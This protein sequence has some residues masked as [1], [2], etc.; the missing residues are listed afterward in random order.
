PPDLNFDLEP[1]TLFVGGL[2]ATLLPLALILPFFDRLRRVRPL[3]L[4]QDVRNHPSR[5]V[6]VIVSLLP[7]GL[8]FWGLAVWVSHSVKIGSLFWGTLLFVSL[9][10]AGVFSQILKRVPTLVP[11]KTHG[12][13]FLLRLSLRN[14]NGHRLSTILSGLSVTVGALLMGLLP[15]IRSGLQQELEAPSLGQLPS[16]FLFDIQEEQISDLTALLDKFGLKM[17]SLTPMVRARLDSVNGKT[18]V[19]VAEDSQN[20]TREEEEAS[21]SRNRG[22]NLTF[23]SSQQDDPQVIQGRQLSAPP[24][25]A[26]ISL[27]SKYAERMGI[28][29]GDQLKFDIQGVFIEGTVVN[30]RNVRWTSFEPNFFIK[31]GPGALEAAPKTYLATLPQASDLVKAS[32][33]KEIVS[34]LPN[35][36]A[37]DVTVVV[38]RIIRLIDD[39]KIALYSMALFSIIVGWI[40]LFTMS[41]GQ[42]LARRGDLN[43]MKTIGLRQRP[44]TVMALIEFGAVS[45]LG[46]FFGVA[47]SLALAHFIGRIVFKQVWAPDW[48]SAFAILLFSV[49]VSL[50]VIWFAIR[51]VIAE[52]PLKLLQDL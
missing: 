42:V 41:N 15:Q 37:V 1:E 2:V 47:S 16:L 21:R 9:L 34:V 27:E 40:V 7:A 8:L 38:G 31:F 33:Q 23:A 26:E 14:L 52:R 39:M 43:L 29:I 32:V 25:S 22:V 11:M 6:R 17:R 49:I 10:V 12:F 45:V 44:L 46:I 4:I 5:P 19:R 51:Q 24:A 18:E 28:G 35:I 13:L 48:A 30:L 36:S 3:S 50:I 20:K